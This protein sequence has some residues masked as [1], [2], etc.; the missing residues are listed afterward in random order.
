MFGAGHHNYVD[1]PDG[2]DP[3][4]LLGTI[5]AIAHG[6][7][8][9]GGRRIPGQTARQGSEHQAG[10]RRRAHAGRRLRRGASSSQ[11]S[12]TSGRVRSCWSPAA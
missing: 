2:Y 5:P 6:L 1:G 3:E 11:W 12:R 9:V 8:G 10:H 7:I 4:G